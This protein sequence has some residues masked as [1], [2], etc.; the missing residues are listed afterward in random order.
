M[1]SWWWLLACGG[2]GAKSDSAD[3]GGG[4]LD[5]YDCARVET[6][7]ALDEAA[8]D[9]RVAAELLAAAGTA[10]DVPLVYEEGGE[11]QLSLSFTATEA[12]W[13]DL[14]Q[15]EPGRGPAPAIYLYCDDYLAISGT[16]SFRTADGAFDAGLALTLSAGADGALEGGGRFPTADLG[17]SFDWSAF[18]AEGELVEA[19]LSLAFDQLSTSGGIGAFTSGDDGS[20]AWAG[21]TAIGRWGAAVE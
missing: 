1:A 20:V 16:L 21:Q 6:P 5:G 19:E 8:P 2:G 4:A 3:T 10:F 17:G 11:T 9:G 12:R 14:E 18:G 13:V 7:L 15:P